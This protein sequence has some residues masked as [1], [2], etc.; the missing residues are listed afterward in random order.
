MK[1]YSAFTHLEVN[2]KEERI[3]HIET[4]KSSMTEILV[5]RNQKDFILVSWICFAVN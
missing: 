5:L 4:N 2:T 3:I 1:R